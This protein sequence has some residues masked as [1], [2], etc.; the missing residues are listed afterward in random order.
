MAAPGRVEGDSRLHR[1]SPKTKLSTTST[2]HDDGY[3][4]SS[5]GVAWEVTTPEPVYERTPTPWLHGYGSGSCGNIRES[6]K[7][8]MV[9]A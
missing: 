4:Q 1:P 2:D 7:K 3:R 6:I 5:L 9:G 8:E